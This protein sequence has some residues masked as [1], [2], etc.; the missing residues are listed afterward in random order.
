M[1]LSEFLKFQEKAG[2]IK[3]YCIFWIVFLV[4]FIIGFLKTLFHMG[5][6]IVIGLMLYLGMILYTLQLS[7]LKKLNQYRRPLLAKASNIKCNGRF[8]IAYVDGRR[9]SD[10]YSG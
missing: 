7:L 9:I 3:K 8:A 6:G 1:I 5:A 4:L 2:I 10:E